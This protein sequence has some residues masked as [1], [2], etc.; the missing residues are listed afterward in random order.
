[1]VEVQKRSNWCVPKNIKMAFLHSFLVMLYFGIISVIAEIIGIILYNHRNCGFHMYY[2]YVDWH[3]S[4]SNYDSD[5]GCQRG[6]FF[7][8]KLF[9]AKFI[10]RQN[11][12]VTPIFFT[13]KNAFLR[14]YFF[15]PKNAF[16]R[17]NFVYG[18]LIFYTKELFYA[19]SLGNPNSDYGFV[20]ESP[21]NNDH[22]QPCYY[23]TSLW[24]KKYLGES[25]KGL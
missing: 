4:Y 21:N 8:P 3:N 16:V 23:R 6:R 13:P 25:L 10:W 22:L 15:T 19:K 18:R 5:K 17:Q 9:Y 1:M 7:T 24:H 2:D 20:Q 14:Q 12:C 11:N